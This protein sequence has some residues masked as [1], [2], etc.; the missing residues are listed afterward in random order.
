MT[1]T[2]LLLRS[3]PLPAIEAE[4]SAFLA[5]GWNVAF[6]HVG[7]TERLIQF[8]EQGTPPEKCDGQGVVHEPAVA[9]VLVRD[10]TP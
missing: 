3:G 10:G 7:H 8:D 5:E 2:R 6:L 1:T 9:V 4:L